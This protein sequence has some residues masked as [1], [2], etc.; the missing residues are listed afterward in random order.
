ME[1][2]YKYN[3]EKLLEE[4]YTYI[5]STYNEHYAQN[6]YQ[7]TEF[8]L[9]SGHG[10]G[11]CIGNI[12][13]YTQRYSHKGDQAEWRKDLMKVI[14]YAVIALYN[15]D[16]QNMPLELVAVNSEGNENGTEN[17]S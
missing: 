2:S 8:I 10:V 5:N 1:I 13:K 12:M 9:D 17:P 15:H 14:H 3:E 4:V 7:A 6:K 16:Q 11:F